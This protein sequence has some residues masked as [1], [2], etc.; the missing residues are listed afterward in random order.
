M[1]GRRDM[2]EQVGTGGEGREQSPASADRAHLSEEQAAQASTEQN[3]VCT[4]RGLY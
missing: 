2:A 3:I 4:C 1:E